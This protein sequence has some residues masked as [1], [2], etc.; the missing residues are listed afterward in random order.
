[1]NLEVR[2]V[3]TER[4]GVEAATEGLADAPLDIP[5]S[6]CIGRGYNVHGGG[7]AE[8]KYVRAPL[9]DLTKKEKKQIDRDHEYYIPTNVA[10]VPTRTASYKSITGKTI[11]EYQS[12]LCAA[13]GIKGSY[14]GF[15]G[16]LETEFHTESFRR[17]FCEYATIMDIIERWQLRLENPESALLPRAVEELHELPP[18]ELFDKYGTHYLKSILVGA[19]ANYSCTVDTHRYGS[20]FKLEAVAE[21]SYKSLVKV[22]VSAS[23]KMQQSVEE[24]QEN[25]TT[26]VT[27]WGGNP[28]FARGIANGMYEQWSASTDQEPVF[29]SFGDGGLCPIW[30][31]CSDDRREAELREAAEAY[32]REK[33]G[34]PRSGKFPLQDNDRIALQADTGLYLGRYT[35]DGH[36]LILAVK[37]KIEQ[38]STFTVKVVGEGTEASDGEQ[39]YLL[40]D[41]HK[42][43]GMRDFH[44]WVLEAWVDDPLSVPNSPMIVRYRDNGKIT[45]QPANEVACLRREMRQL[46]AEEWPAIVPS[47]KPDNELSQFSVLVLNPLGS[48]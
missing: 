29:M 11:E 19:R 1:M 40:A 37:E 5:G 20:E 16:S 31:L 21:A 4:V 8:A 32:A 13:V 6:A 28:R 42:Y 12:S 24:L 7:Y 9:F 17:S 41:N 36:D 10:Y 27:T 18:T 48:D 33:G 46:G 45:L 44:A 25:S 39:I 15:T 22:E 3:E 30:E 43:W 23:L 35:I 47:G 2:H 38:W 14:L 34:L 26:I